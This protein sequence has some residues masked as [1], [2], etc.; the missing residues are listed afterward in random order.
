MAYSTT[1]WGASAHFHKAVVLRLRGVT[2]AQCGG[3]RG[4]NAHSAR[5]ERVLP[6]S[7]EEVVLKLRAAP[8]V[9]A[10]PGSWQIKAPSWI[11]RRASG[12][13]ASPSNHKLQTL[14]CSVAGYAGATRTGPGG[15]VCYHSPDAPDSDYGTL[16]LP[17][18]IARIA[19][20][21]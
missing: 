15:R 4:R 5:R 19:R 10:N 20:K 3:V 18:V 14:N 2:I 13:L 12:W 6:Q 17:L 21:M 11:S 9:T 16:P 1:V 7:C 8:I